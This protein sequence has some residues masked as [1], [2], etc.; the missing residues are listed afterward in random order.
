MTASVIYK[1]YRLYAIDSKLYREQQHKKQENTKPSE[2]LHN[3][4]KQS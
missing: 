1:F 3:P 4:I 2:Q